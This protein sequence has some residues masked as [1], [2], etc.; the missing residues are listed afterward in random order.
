MTIVKG[1]SKFT[2]EEKIGYIS[3]TFNLPDEFAKQMAEYRHRDNQHL[4]DDFSENTLSNYYLPF[5][6]APN[7][8]INNR[9]Y[10]V[11]MVIE[12]SS[13]V[14]AA[15]RAAAF[16]ATQGGFRTTVENTIKVGH[17]WFEWAGDAIE[18]HL[19]SSRIRTYL[20]KNVDELTHSMQQRGGG[21]IDMLFIPQ[22][23]MPGIWQLQVHFKTGD[24]MGANFINSCLEAMKE[25]LAECFLEHNLS[26]PEIL[27]AILSNHTPDCLVTC[28]VECPIENLAPYT[29]SL[30]PDEFARRFKL[31]VDIAY[32]NTHRAVT[33]NKGIYNGVDAVILATGNDFR[34]VEAA[35]H[36]FAAQDG[37]YRSLS[38]CQLT[39]T[40][41]FQFSL[42]I[43]LAIG[44]VGGLTRLHPLAAQA[45]K[46][47]QQ[48]N[49][50]ELMGIAA[51]AGLANNFSA[52]ASLVTT[53][54]QKGHMK[55]H[56]SNILNSM[57]ITEKEKQL[58]IDYFKDKTVSQAA[59]KQFI[60]KI[61]TKTTNKAEN[62]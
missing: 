12:E 3:Q 8:L 49:A 7:F 47:L 15:S 4:F 20:I 51:A 41:V 39:D 54:I 29:G 35:G 18:L 13:V 40:G 55:L 62:E 2:R 52:V 6:V 60:D 37:Q 17:I 44:T 1:F 16:W 14:A 57:G 50:T 48:P 45:M 46:L 56:L 27:M 43:P 19:N 38:Q 24:S 36:A 22:K 59:V 5:G 25:P 23:G 10:A 58:T 33:H 53:G 9:L 34:A 30:T 11:P 26:R 21:I 32:N 61:K 42:T 28:S 31:A